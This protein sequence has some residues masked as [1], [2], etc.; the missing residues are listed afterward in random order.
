M[1]GNSISI[2]L[3]FATAQDI[4]V[5][6]SGYSSTIGGVAYSARYDVNLATSSLVDDMSF[7]QSIINS[8][9][10]PI[11]EEF[12]TWKYAGDVSSIYCSDALT[13]EG[14]NKTYGIDNIS[15]DDVAGV[16]VNAPLK[17]SADGNIYSREFIFAAR[18]KSVLDLAKLSI[19]DT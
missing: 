1:S 12:D 8:G 5:R 14:I 17:L 2:Q 11:P 18:I 19:I 6:L 15:Q 10:T 9:I 4:E 7:S 13:S 16:R 3:A